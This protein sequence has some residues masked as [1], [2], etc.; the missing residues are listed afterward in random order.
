MLILRVR[1]EVMKKIK[2]KTQH[3]YYDD[4]ILNVAVGVGYSIVPLRSPSLD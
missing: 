2:K 3:I 4:R 1:L